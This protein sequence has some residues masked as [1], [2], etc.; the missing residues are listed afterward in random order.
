MLC[1]K[2]NVIRARLGAMSK[3]LIV[4]SLLHLIILLSLVGCQPGTSAQS[5]SAVPMKQSSVEI[6][7]SMDIDE[8]R[9]AAYALGNSND[10]DAVPKSLAALDDP[11]LYVRIYAIQSLRDLKDDRAVQR[12]CRLLE[13]QASE[14]LIVSNVTIALGSI[15]SPKAIP[16]LAAALNSDEP[17]TRYEAAFALGQIGDP[18]AI[19]ALE[20]LLSDKTKPERFNAIGLLEESTVYTVGEQAQRAIGMIR[21]Q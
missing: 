18:S 16:T 6:P 14:P 7:S 13:E 9:T 20:K 3:V 1:R 8:R 15:R 11:D 12:L 10:T 4:K 21:S 17:F 19:P 2:L 5:G